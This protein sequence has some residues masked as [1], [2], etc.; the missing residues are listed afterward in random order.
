MANG[1]DISFVDKNDFE[2]S[3]QRLGTKTFVLL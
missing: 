3:S 1:A 2:N